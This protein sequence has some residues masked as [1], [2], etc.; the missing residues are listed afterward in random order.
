MKNYRKN[1]AK[2]VG[3]SVVDKIINNLPF[4][5]HLPGY[6]YCGPGT[7]VR[8]RLDRGDLG[9]NDLD[10]SC[11]A[12]DIFYLNNK[13][14]AE[15]RKADLVL[16]KQA[17]ERVKSSNS[18]GEK[19]SALAVAGIM[20]AKTSLGFGMKKKK[21]GKK[22][23]LKNNRVNAKKI[24]QQAISSAS[25]M[26]TGESPTSITEAAKM[27]L[28]AA[29]TVIRKNNIPRE[30]LLENAPRILPVPKVG[31]IIPLIPLFAGLSAL[32]SL[33]G[34]A[35]TIAKAVN[36]AKSANDSL[37]ENVRH[38]KKMES[39]ALGKSKTGSGLYLKP[40]RN[41]LGLYLRPY[42]GNGN[43]IPKSNVKQ[44]N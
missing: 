35:S 33:I 13:D 15:R 19:A 29:R 8:E 1:T 41:G 25:E 31:G 24:L 28:K 20:K 3:G 27:A 10:K 30:N 38:N 11:K 16:S 18:L 43:K 5:L 39:I 40:Y 9:I 4:E 17:W 26:V 21:N 7:K 42:R 22:K 12:H 2:V 44:K 6:Q 37:S 23:Q 32:G 14:P 36:I 34:G